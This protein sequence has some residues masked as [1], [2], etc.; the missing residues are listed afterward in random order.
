RDWVKPGV[1]LAGDAA[2]AMHPLAGQ[3]LNVGLG[4]AAELN[5]VLQDR[6]YWRELGDLKLLRKYER[7]RKAAFSTMGNMTDGLFNLF[8]TDNRL[9]QNLRNLGLN[10]IDKMGP[11][12]TWLTRQATGSQP[13]A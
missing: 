2:H 10:G 12:K 3:G 4:D 6:E 8:H 1:A 11:V 7:S 13:T 5:R 9:L